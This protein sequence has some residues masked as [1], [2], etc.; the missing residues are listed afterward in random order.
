MLVT[1]Y[2]HAY[3]PYHNA[4]AETTLHDLLVS[5]VNAGHECVVVLKE[6]PYAVNREYEVDGVK[7]IQAKDKRTLLHYLPKSDLIITHLECSTRATLLANKFRIPVAQLIHNNL[8]LTRTYIGHGADF[9]IYNTDWI[10][11]DFSDEFSKIPSVTVHPPILSENYA[12]TRGKKVTLVNLF[13]RKGQDIFYY[14]VE[15]MPDVEFLAVKGGYG[16]QV[17]KEFPNLEFMENAHDMK[18][19]YENTKVVL[20]P[21][22]YESYGRVACEALAS[23]IPNIVT[24]TQ[25]L[26]EALGPAGIY[27]GR[28]NPGDW[29]NAL[30][31]LLTP[32]R[33]GAMSKLALERSVA[34]DVMA[35]RE[36]DNFVL[37]CEQ[38]VSIY[39]RKR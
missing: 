9:V 17:I 22:I 10:K 25:G 23:G 29:L 34:L 39:K 5:L 31:A 37:F 35:K 15:N 4:G 32:R 26:M 13:E 21:S 36:L 19:V 7:V 33:Y 20:M 16:E 11:V 27:V 14:L 8:D 30:K 28:E 6:S 12:T 38:F 2:V 3:V 24:P 1:S 18:K